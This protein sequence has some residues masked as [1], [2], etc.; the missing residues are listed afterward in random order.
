[1]SGPEDRRTIAALTIAGSDSSGGAGIQADLKTFMA[2]GVYGASAI[3]ALT[4]QNTTGVSD[5]HL[6][7]T[8]HIRAQIEAVLSDLRVGAI[9]TGML[10][11]EAQIEAV[12][13]SLADKAS[14]IPLVVDPVMVATSGARLL[15]PGAENALV[16]RL[17]PLAHLITPNLAEAA[18]LLGVPVAQDDAQA[19]AQAQA[20][21]RLGCK[22][23][24]V[25]GG[26]FSGAEASDFY[27]DGVDM[28]QFSRPRVE[29]RNT[30]GT[31]CTLASAITAGLALGRPMPDAIDAAKDFLHL[32]LVAGQ[33]L[34]IGSGAGPLDHAG[35]MASRLREG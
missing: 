25:K 26:H 22:A 33:A 24:L 2:M 10:G 19:K 3:T 4:A 32:A 12:A 27:F 6:V 35:A 7:P 15:E 11:G 30:H 34:N 21:L 9:K 13:E 5:I 23:V 28:R 29:T 14:N 20:L 8:S 17:I 16:S 1:V 31:G 18:A